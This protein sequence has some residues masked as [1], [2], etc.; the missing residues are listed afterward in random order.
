E[1][2]ARRGYHISREYTVDPLERL[3]LGDVMTTTVVSVPSSLSLYDLLNDYFLAGQPRKHQGYPV[4]DHNGDLLGVITKSNLLE[5]W[6][7]ARASIHRKPS[8]GPS[9]NGETD[10]QFTDDKPTDCGSAESAS[11]GRVPIIA[12]D[13]ISRSPVTAL[14]GESCRVAAERMAQ[15]GVGR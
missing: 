11:S 6:L 10:R 12:Y 13:L 7:G 3:T 9:N 15:M 1:K 4:I 8:A 2:V 5:E 14:A